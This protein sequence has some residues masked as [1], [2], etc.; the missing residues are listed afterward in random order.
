MSRNSWLHLDDLRESWVFLIV[1]GYEQSGQQRDMES[2]VG[3]VAYW[4]LGVGN[5]EKLVETT[6]SS[7]SGETAHSQSEL[8][9]ELLDDLSAYRY[10][11]TLL[12]TPNQSTI[13]CLRAALVAADV[14]TPSLRGFA[15]VDIESLLE[16]QFGQ[17]LNDYGLAE[18]EWQRPR[19][20]DDDQQRV[21]STGTLDRVWEVWTRVYRLVPGNLLEGME[22]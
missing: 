1:G 3:E 4:E 2:S 13:Q 8:L 9:T 10:Q 15:H 19:V 22:L 17:S 16:C 12:V 7:L 11:D 18:E 21:V 5:P 6:A 14:V 20:T